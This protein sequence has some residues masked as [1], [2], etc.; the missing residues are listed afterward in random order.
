MIVGTVVRGGTVRHFFVVLAPNTQPD[1]S[2][3][4]EAKFSGNQPSSPE[5]LVFFSQG[6]ITFATKSKHLIDTCTTTS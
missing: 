5:I 2:N 1:R 3:L 6:E 4:T